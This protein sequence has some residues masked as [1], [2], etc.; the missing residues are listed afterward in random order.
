MIVSA[1]LAIHWLRVNSADLIVSLDYSP[2]AG[3]RYE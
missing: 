2:A 3:L 1:A